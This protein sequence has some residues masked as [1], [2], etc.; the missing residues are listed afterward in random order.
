MAII[1][2]VQQYLGSSQVN[3][4]SRQLGVDQNTTERAISSALPMILGGMAGHAAQP[5]GA[6]TIKQAVATHANATDNIQQLVQTGPPADV[7]VSGGLLGRIL[8]GHRDTVEQGVQQTSGLDPDKT[9]RLLMML[10]PIVLGVIARRQFGGKDAQQADPG[11]LQGAL[12]QEAQTAAK[13][14]PHVGG[15]LGKILGAVESPRA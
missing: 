4:I 11:Q 9:K 12:H 5:Q 7:G 8:G 1:D 6:E 10:A 13:E 2:T 14:S 15:L 3:E